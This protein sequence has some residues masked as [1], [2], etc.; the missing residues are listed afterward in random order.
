L[1]KQYNPQ[2]NQKGDLTGKLVNLASWT[3]FTRQLQR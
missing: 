1:Q 2:D 3:I